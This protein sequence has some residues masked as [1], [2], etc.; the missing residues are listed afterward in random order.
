MGEPTYGCNLINR[1]YQYNGVII[2]DLCKDDIIEAATKWEP[3]CTISKDDITIVQEL[4]TVYIYIL[5]QNVITG[6]VEEL[7]LSFSMDDNR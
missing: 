2:Q 6:T 1:I 7:D 3:R 5:Y 4:R